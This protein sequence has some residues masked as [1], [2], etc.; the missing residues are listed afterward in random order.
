MRTVP[1]VTSGNLIKL[2]QVPAV[3]L[4]ALASL[5]VPR[6]PDRWVVGCGSGVG[7]GALAL[8]IAARQRGDDVAWVARSDREARDAEAH[9]L[10]PVR[11]WRAFSATLRAGVVVI[12]HGFGDVSRAGVHGA[13]VV[14]LWHGIPLKRLHRDAPGFLRL[15]GVPDHPLVRRLL[16]EAH[17]RSAARIRLFPVA[18]RRVA[19]RIERAFGIDEARV[20]VLGDPRIDAL[21]GGDE[22]S[23]RSR[24]EAL[25]DASG[26]RGTTT[27]LY[28]P[29]WRDGDPDPAVPS[30]VQWRAIAAWLEARD[31]RLV[32]RSHP[33]G[34]GDYAQ[35]PRTSDRVGIL[36]AAMVPDVTPALPGVDMLITDFSSI[37]Y[38]FAGLDRPTLLLTPDRV[39]YES[40]RGLYDDYAAFAG[41]WVT[42]WDALLPWADAVLAGGDAAEE[43]RSHARRLVAETQEVRGGATER[44]LAAIDADL[45]AGVAPQQPVAGALA[46]VVWRDGDRLRVRVEREGTAPVALRLRG[47]RDT[48]DGELSASGDLLEASVPLTRSR[49]GQPSVPLASG[50]WVLELVDA[51]G[52]RL[53]LRPAAVMPEPEL[54]LGARVSV[55]DEEGTLVVR[56]EPGL[57]DAERAPGAQR[58]LERTML[59]HPTPERAVMLESFYASTASCNPR[60][61]DAALAR[62]APDVTRY[63]SVRD[64]SVVVPDGGVPLVEGSTEWWRVRGAARVLVVNDWLRKRW[65]RQQHQRVLQTWHGTPLKRLA[66]ERSGQSLRTRIASVLEGR[67]WSILLAQNPHSEQHLRAA[68]RFAGPI[69]QLGYPRSDVLVHGDVDAVRDRLGV[70][71]GT[72]IVLYAPTWRDDR[73]AVVDHI[74]VGAL[75]SGLGEEWRVV[76]R[77][78]SRSVD[79]GSELA[80]LGVVDATTYPDAADL[81]LVADVLV[82][83]YSSVMFDF[84]ATGR[85]IVLAVPD[86]A[87]YRDRLRGFTLDLDADAPG[88]VVSTAAQVVEAVR[89]AGPHDGWQQR[90]EAWRARFTPLD[91]G[92]A[93]ER[94]VRRMLADGLLD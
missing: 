54:A 13:Y 73:A 42:S 2:L 4:G 36:P 71:E 69:W 78:H 58:R 68:Y 79:A 28:A 47:P 20:R 76:V 53:A 80:E 92:G 17:R 39:A 26:A 66:L 27:L 45:G 8:A 22:A 19:S 51:D 75:A 74:D 38:D 25:L 52:V 10:R 44:V 31:A 50:T 24:A 1:R 72:R 41:R 62:L 55:R 83:D 88:P 12:T 3:A 6:R 43:R 65:R 93:G 46:R 85:P 32:V 5:V 59:A 7:E 63:W 86:L 16:R 61:I 81:L 37:A 33:H 90:R 40:S 35:G 9:G 91:D 89:G 21:V 56:M 23:R 34:S 48:L 87:D 14:N 70:P 49:W 15:P 84:A 82:T 30:A 18:S 64:G 67:R 77:G 29:T 60:A 11:G 94:V 57:T